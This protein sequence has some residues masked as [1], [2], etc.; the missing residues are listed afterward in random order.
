MH[1]ASHYY[2]LN[3]KITLSVCE[4]YLQER[5]INENT[6]RVRKI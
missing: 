2:Y 6:L 3:E 4:N 5:R 1:L